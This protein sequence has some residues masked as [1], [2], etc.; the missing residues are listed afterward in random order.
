MAPSDY[1]KIIFSQPRM[2]LSQIGAALWLINSSSHTTSQKRLVSHESNS[3]SC[4][5]T[6]PE[7]TMFHP[8]LQLPNFSKPSWWNVMFPILMILALSFLKIT[9]PSLSFPSP[10]RGETWPYL[11]MKKKW[12]QRTTPSKSVD[13]ISLANNSAWSPITKPFGIF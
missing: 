1:T 4:F 6:T 10:C 12:W 3:H 9:T 11:F 7:C 13:L 8:M 2:L 5:W